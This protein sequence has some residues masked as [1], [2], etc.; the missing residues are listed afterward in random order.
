[1][2]VAAV[3]LRVVRFTDD[4]AKRIDGLLSRMRRPEGT[5]GRSP[6]TPVTGANARWLAGVDALALLEAGASTPADE[7]LVSLINDLDALAGPTVVALDDYHVIDDLAVHE[8]VTFL[9]DNLPPQVTLAMTTRAD[10]PLALSRLRAR[11]EV[12]EL[13]AADLRFSI[14]EA[15]AFLNEVMELELDPALVHARRAVDIYRG[16]GDAAGHA[17]KVEVGISTHFYAAASEQD[18]ADVFEHYHV[19]LHPNA[20]G[21][22]GFVVDRP[23]FDASRRRRGALMIGTPDQLIEKIA[24][25]QPR[26]PEPDRLAP[27]RQFVPAALREGPRVPRTW[28]WRPPRIAGRGVQPRH[29]RSRPWCV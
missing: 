19:Y 26:G 14:E 6:A 11:D 13:R 8:A 1:V 28:R 23:T 4:S 17:D 10:P 7:V 9:L 29:V 2:K 27:G 15:E 5:A 12:V 20:N 3:F 16:A 24:R 22:R 25:W 21:G 18:A